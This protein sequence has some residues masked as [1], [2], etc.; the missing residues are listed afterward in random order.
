MRRV[1]RGRIV[2]GGMSG[3][4]EHV[5]VPKM[6]EGDE[7]QDKVQPIGSYDF[8]QLAKPK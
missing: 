1:V 2:E 5:P 6:E 3:A 7:I 8:R 4:R